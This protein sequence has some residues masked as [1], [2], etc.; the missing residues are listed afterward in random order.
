MFERLIILMLRLREHLHRNGPVL[1][2]DGQSGAEYA[3]VLAGVV[4]VGLVAMKV[5]GG[6][7]QT[8]YQHIANQIQATPAPLPGG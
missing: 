4:L 3:L 2:E 7:V 1:G 8:S 5:L 6:A